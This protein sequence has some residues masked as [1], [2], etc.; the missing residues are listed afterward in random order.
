MITEYDPNI[1]D[2]EIVTIVENFN[3]AGI[4]TLFSC[5]G[6]FKDSFDGGGPSIPYLLTELPSDNNLYQC[7][8]SGKYPN[9][10]MEAE[11]DFDLE[12]TEDCNCTELDFLS[13]YTNMEEYKSNID[14]LL[15]KHKNYRLN[16][17]PNFILYNIDERFYDT[18]NEKEY[19]E[20]FEFLRKKFITELEQLSIDLLKFVGKE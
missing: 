4:K 2:P 6:H 19:E 7:I 12:E 14:K 18:E 9:I 8:F 13:N 20:I 10:G 11:T 17:T 16:F 5:Q 3:K 1:I 15:N